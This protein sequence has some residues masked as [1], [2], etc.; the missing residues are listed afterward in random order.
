MTE[1]SRPWTGKDVSGDVGPYL[2][3]EWAEIWSS[4]FQIDPTTEGILYIQGSAGLTVTNPAAQTFRVGEGYAMV[5]GC[6]YSNDANIDL[7]TFIGN[8]SVNPRIDVVVLE[9]DFLAQT[10]RAVIVTGAEAASPAAPAMTQNSSV[11]Q[12]PLAQYQISTGGIISNLTDRRKVCTMPV[13]MLFPIDEI[14]LQAA[15]G[16]THTI[17]NIPG[18]FSSLLFV[19]VGDPV[20][21]GGPGERDISMRLNGDTGSKY[22][23]VAAYDVVASTV[24]SGSLTATAIKLADVSITTTSTGYGLMMTGEI[25]QYTN[26]SL[27]TR[28]RISVSWGH[29]ISGGTGRVGDTG[30]YYLNE[31]TPVTSI[32]IFTDGTNFGTVADGAKLLLYGRI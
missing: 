8:P 3:S 11:W 29:N 18:Y 17:S 9:K 7:V 24:I 26:V 20:W 22:S 12:I 21:S 5:D 32:T 31:T 19:L 25:S 23:Y 28:V 14:D 2:D 13:G 16:A 4:F 10:V 15:G 30:G 1:K 6:W 27:T